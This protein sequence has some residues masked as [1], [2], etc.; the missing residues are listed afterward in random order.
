MIEVRIFDPPMCCPTG[1][2]GP[3]PDTRLIEFVETIA[4]LQKKYGERIK[5]MRGAVGRDVPLFAGNRD[6]IEI[7]RNKGLR[8]LPIVKV[9]GTIAFQGSYPSYEALER[10]IEAGAR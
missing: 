4:K 10:Q 6:V 8:A 2:C 5:I 7:V 9:S 1:I 3:A